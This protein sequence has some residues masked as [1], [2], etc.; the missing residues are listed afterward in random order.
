M[1]NSG[2]CIQDPRLP[3]HPAEGG[4]DAVR[5]IILVYDLANTYDE[6]NNDQTA[7]PLE[8]PRRR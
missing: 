7:E 2:T 5:G 8:A 4:S 3:A 6:V 1:Y